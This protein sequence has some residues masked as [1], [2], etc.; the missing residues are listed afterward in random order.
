MK[1]VVLQLKLCQCEKTQSVD[2]KSFNSVAPQPY[3]RFFLL[4]K[5][6]DLKIKKGLI[7][8]AS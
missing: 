5:T 3:P 6:L 7:W 1:N 4:L 8:A 2:K